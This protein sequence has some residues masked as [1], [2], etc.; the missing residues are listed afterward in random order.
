MPGGKLSRV[1][2][3]AMIGTANSM[4]SDCL[5]FFMKFVRCD[6][7]AG[8]IGFGSLEALIKLNGESMSLA[9]WAQAR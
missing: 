7:K 4:T 8:G 9:K 2:A 1:N 3:D 5:I 6:E